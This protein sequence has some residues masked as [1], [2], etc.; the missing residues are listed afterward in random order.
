MCYGTCK[1]EYSFGPHEMTGECSIYL[2][3]GTD[4]MPEDATCMNP[5]YGGEECIDIQTEKLQKS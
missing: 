2:L 3:L 4:N 5:T 1:Y